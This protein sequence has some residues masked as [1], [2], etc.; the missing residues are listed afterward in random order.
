[1]IK[2]IQLPTLIKMLPK[3]ILLLFLLLL[4][5]FSKAQTAPDFIVTIEPK[6]HLSDL[7]GDV[8]YLDFWAS[9]C[10]PCRR[11]FPWM[12]RMQNK[13]ADKGFKVITVNLDKKPDLMKQFLK[14]YPAEFIVVK[15]PQAEIADAYQIQSMPSS[16]LINRQGEI[17]I[18]H[19]GFFEKKMPQYEKEIQSLILNNENNQSTH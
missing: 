13:Y 9:W 7:K 1:M 8:I 5:S 18:S 10:K 16:Y 3:S 14:K 17:V 15:D 6:L 11:S 19:V 2:I 12:N 4:T